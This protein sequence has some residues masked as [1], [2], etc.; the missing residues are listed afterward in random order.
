MKKQTIKKTIIACSLF[1]TTILFVGC[2]PKEPT[3]T[4]SNLNDTETRTLLKTL[5]EDANIP[6]QNQNVLFEH[7]DQI[8]A[9]LTKKELTH[10]FETH[11]INQPKYDPYELQERWDN[12]YPDFLGYNCRITAYTLLSNTIQ[13]NPTN[14]TKTDLLLFDLDALETDNSATPQGTT[15]FEQIF[16]SIPTQNTKDTN[17]HLAN[18]QNDWKQRNIQFKK[19]SPIHMISLVLHDQIDEDQLFIGH[20]GTLFTNQEGTLYFLEKIAFQE[21]YQLC[22]FNNRKELNDYLML[23]YNTDY[24][25][26]N[27][28]PLILEDDHLI[29]NYQILQSQ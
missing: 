3:I 24:G 1:L 4:Y 21:P 16:S 14:H 28:A 17:T 13:T 10:G 20:V 7:I 23:K 29:E 26:T 11:P 5:M 12:T 15:Q 27:A 6:T 22:K 19:D 2:Q 18:L 9:L 25:Q 8:N